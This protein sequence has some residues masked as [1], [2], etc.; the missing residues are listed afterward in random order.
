MIGDEV[1]Q[2]AIIAKLKANT[3]L[4]AAL[5]SSTDIKEFEWQGDAFG[6]PN[7]RVDLEENDFVFDEQKRC[8]LQYAQFSV[9]VYSQERSS[10]QTSQI[11][12]I[13]LNELVG[14]GFTLG[15]VKFSQ[16]RLLQGGNVPAVREDSRTWRGQV[17]FGTRVQSP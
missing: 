10:K 6:F 14:M 7:V 4:V 11:K 12:T 15:G 17:R 2:A 5:G 3:A 1:I 8:E 13:I 9:Y 16:L